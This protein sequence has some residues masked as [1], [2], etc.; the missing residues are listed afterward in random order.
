M[1]YQFDVSVPAFGAN[2][3]SVIVYMILFGKYVTQPLRDSY[4]ISNMNFAITV[5]H[6]VKYCK[7][8]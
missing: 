5:S 2:G 7:S 1:V 6:N 8:P 3:S 4:E